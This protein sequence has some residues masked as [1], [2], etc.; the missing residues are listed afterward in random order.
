MESTVADYVRPSHANSHGLRKG[1][2]TYVTSGTTCHPPISSVTGRGE[3]S[4]G[5]L[6]DI[7]WTFRMIGDFYLDKLLAGYDPNSSKFASF[8]THFVVGIENI[9]VK[10]A[11]ESCFRKIIERCNNEFPNIQGLLLRC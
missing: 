2:G 8:P 3:W 4:M 7:Y 5:R 6:F 10:E 9:H 11:L 1:A